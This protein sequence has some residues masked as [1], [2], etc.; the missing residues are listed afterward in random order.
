[1]LKD[2]QSMFKETGGDKISYMRVVSFL[3]AL[4]IV[5]VMIVTVHSDRPFSDVEFTVV[6]AMSAI[7]LGKGI[8]KGV[9]V[10]SRK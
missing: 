10:Y 7:L 9:E 3:F 2:L 1:M 8:Q 6:G 4:A 5:Y